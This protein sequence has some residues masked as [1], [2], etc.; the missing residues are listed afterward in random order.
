MLPPMD[1]SKQDVE[2]TLR[3]TW[4]AVRTRLVRGATAVSDTIGKVPLLASIVPAMQRDDVPRDETHYFLI[5]TP[6]VASGYSLYSSRRLPRGVSTTNDLPRLR[7]FHLPSEGSERQLVDL[8][9]A[10]K[11][12]GVTIEPAAADDET[13][14]AERL[15]MIAN[16]IDRHERTVT[17]GIL[18][19]GGAVAVANPLLGVGIAAKAIFPSI[20]A[21]LSREGL[22]L[23]SDKV[24]TWTR[25]REEA[26]E[27]RQR[28]A[29]VEAIRKEFEATPVTSLVNPFLRDL[30]RAL[31]TEASEFDPRLDAVIDKVEVEGWNRE[32]LL[33]LTGRAIFETYGDA[34]GEC[35]APQFRFGPEDREWL[36]TLNIMVS[37]A[38]VG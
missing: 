36:K 21:L 20:G 32:Q 2:Q 4:D 10:G 27:E 37:R 22:K 7:V 26:A 1:L 16:E 9:V 3:E 6:F 31:L 11:S 14:L 18:L 35:V 17:G 5:P 33:D 30:E 19:I 12:A 8:F 25:R 34:D 23:A 13:P 24:K 28:E 15:Q 29:E 38:V